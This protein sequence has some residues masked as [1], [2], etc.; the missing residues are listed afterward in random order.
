MGSVQESLQ[1]AYDKASEI[2]AG[3]SS[4]EEQGW[5][6][7][8][9]VQTWSDKK[10]IDPQ[11]ARYIIEYVKDFILYPKP[12]LDNFDGKTFPGDDELI[13]KNPD[14][15][16]I[17]DDLR[18]VFSGLDKYPQMRVPFFSLL[19]DLLPESGEFDQGVKKEL[20]RYYFEILSDPAIKVD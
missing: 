3:V 1:R 12:T 9:L 18:Q 17:L 14:L 11:G 4:L 2:L 7:N 15:P 8:Q 13:Q 19:L 10:G 16:S 5:I 20:R 6:F